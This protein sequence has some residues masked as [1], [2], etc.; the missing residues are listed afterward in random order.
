MYIYVYVYMCMY[1]YNVYKYIFISKSFLN[2]VQINKHRH[3]IHFKA[4]SISF[5]LFEELFKRTSFNS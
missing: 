3:Q 1:V 2:D 5:Y 4:V